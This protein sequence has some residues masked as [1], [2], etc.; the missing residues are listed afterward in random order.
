[1]EE[2]GTL[3]DIGFKLS[4]LKILKTKKQNKLKEI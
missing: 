2:K 1:M 3:R 4:L